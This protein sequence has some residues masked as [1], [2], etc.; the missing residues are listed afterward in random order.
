MGSVNRHISD[1]GLPLV[2]SVIKLQSPFV[3]NVDWFSYYYTTF[4]WLSANKNI[5]NFAEKFRGFLVIKTAE[6]FRTC[7]HRRKRT[8]FWQFFAA[9]CVKNPCHTRVCLRIFALSSTKP[10]QK[11]VH[12]SYV[13]RLLFNKTETKYHI[14]ETNRPKAAAPLAF[15]L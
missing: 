12:L 14:V 3:C 4:P 5:T 13:D 6:Q 2:R 10:C 8:S 1:E 9:D 7:P 11:S 15:L